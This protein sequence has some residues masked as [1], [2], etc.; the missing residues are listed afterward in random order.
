MICNDYGLKILLI[1]QQNAT[2]IYTKHPL[3]L[4]YLILYHFLIL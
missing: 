2:P 4:L 3:D 1:Y